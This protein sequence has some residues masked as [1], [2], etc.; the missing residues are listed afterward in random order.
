MVAIFVL[1]GCGVSAGSET[2]QLVFEAE[3][4]MDSGERFRV[5][6]GVRNMGQARFRDPQALNAAMELRNDSGENLGSIAVATLWELAPGNAGWPAAYASKLPAG[7]YQLTWGSPDHGSVTVD[8][9]IVELDGWLY[10][11][12][13]SIQNTPSRTQKDEREYGALQSLVEVARANLAQRLAVETEAV[14]VHS[15]EEAEFPDASLGLPEPGQ[16]YA[17]VLTPGYT[18]KLIAEAQVYEYRVSDARLL[19]VPP[20]G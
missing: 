18:I 6:L 16:T 1:V 9:T 17:Q 5:S 14:G 4:N 20:E 19:F 2:A 8:F 15:I 7:A 10:L 3:M 11:G 12:K 13:E